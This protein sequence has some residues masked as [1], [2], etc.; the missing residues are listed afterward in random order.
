[1]LLDK[2]LPELELPSQTHG[3]GQRLGV[4]DAN[5]HAER[6]EEAP[7]EQLDTLSFI[8]MT[9]ARKERL[10]PILVLGDSTRAPAIRQLE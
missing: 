5:I 4:L 2:L 9:G 8:E 10:K 1:M 7:D 3:G 6:R